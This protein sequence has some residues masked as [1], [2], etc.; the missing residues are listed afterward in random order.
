MPVVVRNRSRSGR[1]RGALRSCSPLSGSAVADAAALTS[2]LLPMMVKAGHDK[3]RSASLYYTGRFMD[4]L[5][6]VVFSFFGV[7]TLL[8]LG[9]G[10][11]ERAPST[12]QRAE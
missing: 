4:G 5:L 3:A 11:K 2:L 6:L 1:S 9:R 12:Q 10:L 7:H 8:W